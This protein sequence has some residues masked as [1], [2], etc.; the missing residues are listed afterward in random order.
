MIILF[1]LFIDKQSKKYAEI[2]DNTTSIGNR[3]IGKMCEI[4]K[5]QKYKNTKNTMYKNNL[6]WYSEW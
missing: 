6:K 2:R 1:I 4:G 5:I 3:C